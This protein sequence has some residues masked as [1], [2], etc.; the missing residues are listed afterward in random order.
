VGFYLRKSWSLFG[1]LVR[2]NLSK[3]GVGMSTGAKAARVGVRPNGSTYVHGGRFGLYYR[4]SSGGGKSASR[5]AIRTLADIQGRKFEELTLSEQRAALKRGEYPGH[6]PASHVG[7]Q[8][9]DQIDPATALRV[10]LASRKGAPRLGTARAGS[11]AT[12]SSGLSRSSTTAAI[13]VPASRLT[14]R[15][16]GPGNSGPAR[17]PDASRSASPAGVSSRTFATRLLGCGGL[18]IAYVVASAYCASQLP[19]AAPRLQE[20]GARVQPT[21]APVRGASPRATPLPDWAQRRLQH[22]REID[23]KCSL[24]DCEKPR[25]PGHRYCEEHVIRIEGPG[26][27]RR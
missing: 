26:A 14:T 22:S 23:A 7:P 15:P 2:F 25:V 9:P 20:S 18:L 16:D 12:S 24:F 11:R 8:T 1:G 17:R 10:Y 5:K 13:S 4:Q 27:L 21:A 19:H 6:A 3:S